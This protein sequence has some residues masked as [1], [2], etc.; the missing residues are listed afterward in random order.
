MG[1]LGEEWL[2]GMDADCAG[3]RLTGGGCVFI[4]FGFS[5]VGVVG[6]GFG[7]S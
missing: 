3:G 6:D 7:W 5:S 4:V 2:R 1:W